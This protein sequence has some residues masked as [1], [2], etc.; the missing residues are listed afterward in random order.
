[1]KSCDT[2]EVIRIVQKFN[3]ALSSFKV[4]YIYIYTFSRSCKCC[5][6]DLVNASL[7]LKYLIMNEKFHVDMAVKI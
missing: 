4:I 3:K 5:N 6:Q 1:M 7:V 2:N